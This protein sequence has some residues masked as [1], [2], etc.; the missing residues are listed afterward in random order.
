MSLWVPMRRTAAELGK[1]LAPSTGLWMKGGLF[2][3]HPQ[4]CEVS[5]LEGLFQ[6]VQLLIE[7]G[8]GRSL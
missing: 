2:G 5:P 3:I 8:V 4:A 7:L 6:D 1:K